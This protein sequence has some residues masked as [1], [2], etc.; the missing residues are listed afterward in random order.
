[1]LVETQGHGI[2]PL[3]FMGNQR[4]LLLLFF[5]IYTWKGWLEFSI[6]FSMI[7][8]YLLI[9]PAYKNIYIRKPEKRKTLHL[10]NNC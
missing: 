2:Y 7:N 4:I 9:S 8:L 5:W 1:M 6:V 10:N 3:C